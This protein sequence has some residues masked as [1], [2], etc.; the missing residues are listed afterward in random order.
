MRVTTTGSIVALSLGGL[1]PAQAQTLAIWITGDRLTNACRA[2][3]TMARNK[4][5]VNHQIAHDSDMCFG[6]VSG[7]V[8]ALMIEEADSRRQETIYLPLGVD[9]KN[10]VEVV[11]N[12]VDQRP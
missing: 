11:A 1:A 6:L 4:G 5:R 2:F 9:R 10:V 8:D 7:A 12:Y 3:L